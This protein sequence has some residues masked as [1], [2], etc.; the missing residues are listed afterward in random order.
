M[1]NI[2]DK[3]LV[4][5]KKLCEK[6]GIKYDSEQ[7]YREAL[8][9]LVGFFDV[10][11]QIDQRQKSWER[12][13]KDEPKGFSL[14]SEGRTCALC[15]HHIMGEMWYDKWGL[16]CMN[17]QE[18][19]NKRII[20]GYVFKD[21]DNEKHIT[22]DSLAHQ[23]GLHYQTIMKLVRQG[24]LKARIGPHGPTVFLRKE[25]PELGKIIE[26]EKAERAKA[27]KDKAITK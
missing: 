13:L 26:R 1:V 6:Q 7:K 17:C 8:H 18:A 27:T 14:P 2:T 21:R 5:F 20:P 11:I 23:T 15:H 19:Y 25:N 24:K 16:K 10:L 9:N 12:R 22:A 3:D 4:E